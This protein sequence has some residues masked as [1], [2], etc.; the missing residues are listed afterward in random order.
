L[1]FCINL[2]YFCFIPLQLKEQH[3]KEAT[4]RADAGEQSVVDGI[5][6]KRSTPTTHFNKPPGMGIYTDKE[7]REMEVV[8]IWS[9]SIRIARAEL[10][11]S[12]R[13]ATT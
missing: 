1:L 10:G 5:L 4:A 13:Y 3:R 11:I 7:K 2:I 12:G 9:E 6:R 8:S